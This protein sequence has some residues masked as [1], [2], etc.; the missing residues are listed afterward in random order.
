MG[1]CDKATSLFLL[2]H[3]ISPYH[4]HSLYL[5]LTLYA[6]ISIF[7]SSR[8]LPVRSVRDPRRDDEKKRRNAFRLLLQGTFSVSRFCLH[9]INIRLG[10]RPSVN[11]TIG[12]A[13]KRSYLYLELIVLGKFLKSICH[14]N[15][16]KPNIEISTIGYYTRSLG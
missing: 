14:K 8:S 12:G 16:M 7:F 2:Y 15:T 11:N 6:R 5:F 10:I 4:T 3:S 13:A 9:T 1:L